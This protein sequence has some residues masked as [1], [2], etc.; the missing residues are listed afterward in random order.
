MSFMDDQMKAMLDWL[1]SSGVDCFNLAVLKRGKDGENDQM[2]CHRTARSR[3]DV[4]KSLGWAG[5]MNAQGMDVYLRPARFLPDG[6]H[7]AWPVIFFD[8]VRQDMLNTIKN[9][10][11]VIKTSTNSH[12]VWIPTTQSLTEQERFQAQSAL[13]EQFAA[14]RGSVSGDHF[15]R[16]VGFKNQKRGGTWVSVCQQIAGPNIDVSHVLNSSPAPQERSWGACASL[17]AQSTVTNHHTSDAKSESEREFGYA[18]GRLRHAKATGMD[19]IAEE[20]ELLADLTERAAGR[21]KSNAAKYA[22]R[23]IQAALKRI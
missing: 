21:G 12:H 4:E 18:I 7:A 23:T 5:A 6:T 9:S 3:A 17:P 2:L 19:L 22:S 14:D 1:Q 10:A 20:N 13:F 11:L 15:G 8:D 16:A